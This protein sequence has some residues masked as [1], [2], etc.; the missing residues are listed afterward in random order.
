MRH[1]PNP[2]IGIN[3]IPDNAKMAEPPAYVLQQLYDFDN[4][5]VLLPSRF[6]PYAYVLG[7]RRQFSAGLGDKALEDTITQPDTKM[8]MQYGLVPVSLIYKLGPEWTI[9]RVIESLRR[10]D[11]W[12]VG[13][14]EK[15]ADLLDE[16]DAT[17]ERKIK[18]GIRDDFWNR[19]G[20]AWRS[21]QAR[22]GQRTKLAPPSSKARKGRRDSRTAP[23][24]S[25]RTAGLGALALTAR[26]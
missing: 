21:Y 17:R 13:G 2:Y 18:Q 4:M 8:C 23:S 24:A 20:D 12:A 19:S 3:Y 10:R 22:T 7:R 15:A 1:E 16:A 9:D 6:V 5:L 26:A 25:G 11:V 14:A